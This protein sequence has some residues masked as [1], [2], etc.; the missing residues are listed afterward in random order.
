MRSTKKQTGNLSINVT[1][2]RF[3]ETNVAAE[4]Q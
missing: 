1:P 3:R 4:K 2:R